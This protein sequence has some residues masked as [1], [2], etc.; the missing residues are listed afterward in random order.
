M[1]VELQRVF[2]D[3]R[4]VL[5]HQQVADQGGV[6][7]GTD[8]NADVPEVAPGGEV[9]HERGQPLQGLLHDVA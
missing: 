6:G 7:V 8:Q 9:V 4:D 2:G 1:A 5:R 3:H